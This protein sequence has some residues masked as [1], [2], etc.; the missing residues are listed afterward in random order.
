MKGTYYQRNKE[1]IK[2]YARKYY[3]EHR[4]EKLAYVNKYNTENREGIN[5][6]KKKYRQENADKIAKYKK[7]V[8][9][10]YKILTGNSYSI[11]H[12]AIKSGK[13]IP[14]P[15]KVCGKIPTEG[16]HSD[17]NKPLD[18]IWLCVEHHHDWHKKNKPIYVKQDG[19]SL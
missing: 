1:K 15:C 2:E 8:R 3:R 5:Q 19:G 13:L 9:E 11:Y 16:H 12:S 7:S 14:Q 10:K 6:R 17:Y 18:V 4:K